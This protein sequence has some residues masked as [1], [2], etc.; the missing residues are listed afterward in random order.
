VEAA[1]PIGGDEGQ[2]VVDQVP[3][4]VLGDPVSDQDEAALGALRVLTRRERP[5]RRR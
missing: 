2:A 4:A 1:V 5:S 3:P